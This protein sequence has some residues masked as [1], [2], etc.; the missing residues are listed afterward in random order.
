MAVV[1][2]GDFHPDLIAARLFWGGHLV[3]VLLIGDGV[4]GA[5]VVICGNICV[6]HAAVSLRHIACHGKDHRFGLDG[7]GGSTVFQSVV[8]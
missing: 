3:T 6:F 4:G 5:L 2:V 1:G 7:Q 8:G